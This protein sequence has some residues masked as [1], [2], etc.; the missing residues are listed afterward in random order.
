MEAGRSEVQG[1]LWLHSKLVPGGGGKQI[2]TSSEKALIRKKC[3]YIC[4][5]PVRRPG[6]FQGHIKSLL[7]FLSCTLL[8]SQ[9]SCIQLNISGVQMTRE[10]FVLKNYFVVDFKKIIIDRENSLS[11]LS[12][13]VSVHSL[14][15]LR[16]FETGSHI[17]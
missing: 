16:C 4:L 6:S 7:P 8:R 12:I 9:S 14:H 15:S 2:K 10:P 5:A 3:S 1:H 11:C 13:Q 17:S